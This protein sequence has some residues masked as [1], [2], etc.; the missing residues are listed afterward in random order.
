MKRGERGSVTVFFTILLIPTIILVS[1][2]SDLARIKLY[3]NQALMTADNYAEGILTEYDNLLKDLYGLF[4]IRQD[5]EGMEAIETIKKYMST[6]FQVNDNPMD[7]SH[8][9]GTFLNQGNTVDGYIP[10]ESAEVNF[11]EFETIPESALSNYKVLSSQIGDFMRYR[12]VNQMM[13]QFSESNIGQIFDEIK[14]TKK[15]FDT[16]KKKESIDKDA[17]SLLSLLKDYYSTLKD[18]KEFRSFIRDLNKSYEVAVNGTG[19]REIYHLTML[20]PLIDDLRNRSYS[21][22]LM[23]LINSEDYSDYLSYVEEKIAE[24]KARENQPP[25]EATQPLSP[26]ELSAKHQREVVMLQKK[27]NIVKEGDAYKNFYEGIMTTTHYKVK[28]DNYVEKANQLLN[29]AN[30]IKDKA[31]WLDTQVNNFEKELDQDKSAFNDNVKESLI[32]VKELKKQPKIYVKIAEIFT[33]NN[34]KIGDFSSSADSMKSHIRDTM[35]DEMINALSNE[36][37]ENIKRLSDE[38]GSI[39]LDPTRY[40]KIKEYNDFEDY[41]S[42]ADI[43]EKD[44]KLTEF[45]GSNKFEKE[46]DRVKSE[47]KKIEDDVK[48]SINSEDNDFEKNR[49][50]GT[51]PRDI[52][53]D[54]GRGDQEKGFDFGLLKDAASLFSKGGF[55]GLALKF[56]TLYYDFGMFSDR[57][58]LYRYGKDKSNVKETLTGFDMTKLNYLYGAELEYLNGGYKSSKSNWN[59]VRN[60]IFVFRGAMN[61]LATYQVAELNTAIVSVAAA[62]G[63]FAVIVDPI[64]RLGVVIAETLQDWNQLKTGGEIPLIKMTTLDLASFDAIKGLLGDKLNKKLNQVEKTAKIHINYKQCLGVILLVFVSNE[65]LNKRTGDLITL[66][67]NNEMQ[68]DDFTSLKFKLE[69][70]KTA[71]K[72]SSGI[73]MNFLF[74]PDGLGNIQNKSYEDLNDYVKGVVKKGTYQQMKEIENFEYRY[75]IIRGY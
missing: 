33:A 66:N 58:D 73:K 24:R 50:N 5:E 57:I 2:F 6:S 61:T 14:D 69:N 43:R 32:H 13:D 72:T 25:G 64:I 67:V 63:P 44:K 53:V 18:L 31:E 74:L 27:D 7:F 52:K 40:I 17:E 71:V 4:A 65:N 39:R 30:Q 46:N 9:K 37:E 55:E 8:F 42:D 68:G 22:G 38:R 35:V 20:P 10:Y 26:E 23:R 70:A 41:L 45:F 62:S 47:Q 36:D 1:V 59:S 12:I 49:V 16:I 48:N 54:L 15:N 51:F 21:Q 60:K 19:V 34:H 3:S 28:F 56:F 29:L 11:G 75:S